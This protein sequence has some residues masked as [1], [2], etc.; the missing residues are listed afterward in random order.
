MARH[1]AICGKELKKSNG[2]I[3]PIC[4]R[5]YAN[6]NLSTSYRIPAAVQITYLKKH[7]IFGDD[8]YEQEKDDTTSSGSQT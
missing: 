1:C 2:P 6:K 8:E 3:G 5:K 4:M 7:E